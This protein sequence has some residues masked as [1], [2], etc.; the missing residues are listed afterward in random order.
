VAA[1]HHHHAYISPLIQSLTAPVRKAFGLIIGIGIGITEVS[2]EVFIF[3]IDHLK[4]GCPFEAC[5]LPI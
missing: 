5:H 3:A 2:F 1:S 4:R